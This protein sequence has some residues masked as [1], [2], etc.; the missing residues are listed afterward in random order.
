MY[1]RRGELPRS[2]DFLTA[3]GG[4]VGYV[5]TWCSAG[6][7]MA[8]SLPPIVIAGAHSSVW[9]RTMRAVRSSRSIGAGNSATAFIDFLL[10]GFAGEWVTKAHGYLIDSQGG[11]RALVGSLGKIPPSSNSP[12]NER[13][14]SA[15]TGYRYVGPDLIGLGFV[16]EDSGRFDIV[17]IGNAGL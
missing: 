4:S 10:E 7:R 11:R 1:L 3:A 5:L 2:L 6:K 8:T 17:A 15:E 9:S 14:P 13:S 12:M 16:T